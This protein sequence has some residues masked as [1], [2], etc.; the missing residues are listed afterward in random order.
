MTQ[1]VVPGV[2]QA[3]SL[4][5]H[6]QSYS[7]TRE[8]KG[9]S[10]PGMDTAKEGT[11]VPVDTVNIS[12]LSRQAVTDANKDEPVIEAAQQENAKKEEQAALNDGKADRPAAKVQ[13]V[14][15]QNGELSIRY[16]DTSDRLVYQLPSELMLRMK[17]AASKSDSSVDTKA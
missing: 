13:F 8:E 9:T 7:T 3:L 12:S 11:P 14:Y 16:M 1:A 15:D 2:A 17:E 5:A 10:L 6:A 4:F